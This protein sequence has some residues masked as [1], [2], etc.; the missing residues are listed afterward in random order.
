MVTNHTNRRHSTAERHAGVRRL[1]LALAQINTQVGALDANVACITQAADKAYAAGAQVA[2]FPELAIPG[3]PPE[4][5]LLKPGFVEDNLAALA[6]LTEESA[7]W[8]GMTL[9]V[10][11][12]D[13]D[14]D[15]YNAAAI[16]HDGQ[17]PASTTSSSCPTTASSTRSATSGPAT[18]A[19]LLSMA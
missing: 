4:D 3:Y 19:D 7:K 10:G 18:R 5:L 13:R 16:L 15:L 6:T 14:D 11:F 12:A 2:C 9:I 8:E 1:R 17:R